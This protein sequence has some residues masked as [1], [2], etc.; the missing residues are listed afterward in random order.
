MNSVYSPFSVQVETVLGEQQ[1]GVSEQ[2]I[3]TLLR[4]GRD[5]IGGTAVRSQ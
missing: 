3:L 2:C 5:C 4:T 1:L